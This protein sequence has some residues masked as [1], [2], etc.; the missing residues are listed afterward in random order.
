MSH[1]HIYNYMSFL[2]LGY[3]KSGVYDLPK[4]NTVGPTTEQNLDLYTIATNKHF[5]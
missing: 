1:S 2:S 5:P 3:M 4:G